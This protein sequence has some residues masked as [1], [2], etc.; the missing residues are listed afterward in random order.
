MK[1]AMQEFIEKLAMKT[2][3]SFNALAFYHDND[4]IIKESLEKE[5]EH[6]M[7]AFNDGKTNAV[8]KKRTSE[9]YYNE[10]YE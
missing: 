6:L 9:E 4:E 7:M 5:K 2:G 8:L 10:L 1:T 3:D